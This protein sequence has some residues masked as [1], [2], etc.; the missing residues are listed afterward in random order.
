MDYIAQCLEKFRQ[1]PSAIKNAVGGF[2]ALAVIYKLEGEY[3][4]DLSFLVVLIAIGEVSLENSSDYLMKKYRLAEE[5]ATDI[6]NELTREVFSRLL[7]PVNPYLDSVSAIKEA[8]EKKLVNLLNSSVA[9]NDFNEAIFTALAADGALQTELERLLL[10]N[11]EK[12]TRDSLILEGHEIAPTIS[13]WLKDFIKNNG[14]DLFNEIALA[15]YLNSSNAKNLRPEEKKMVSKLIKL[16]RNLVFFPESL[17]DVPVK[18]WEIIPL[19][20]TVV[21][22]KPGEIRDVLE[23]EKTSPAENIIK[24]SVKPV[25]AKPLAQKAPIA[26]PLSAP[27]PLVDLEK[28]LNQYGPGSLEYKAI[29]QEIDRLKKSSPKS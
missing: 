25:I 2:E 29:K 18:N 12:L 24:S 22:R 10:N 15:Q 21:E 8:V 5:D 9:A 27:N 4:V 11:N 13:N 28:N 14:S 26:K 6:K 20:K 17:Q 3:G 7:L 16:Y 19:D 1:L 23:E